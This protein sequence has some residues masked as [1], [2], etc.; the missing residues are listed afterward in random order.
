MKRRMEVLEFC[1][2]RLTLWVTFT[3]NKEENLGGSCGRHLLISYGMTLLGFFDKN[4]TH[5][6]GCLV[7]NLPISRTHAKV[8]TPLVQACMAEFVDDN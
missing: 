1:F 7:K 6:Y 8:S 2:F 3:G 5:V 4:G